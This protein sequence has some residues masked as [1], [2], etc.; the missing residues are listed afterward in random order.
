MQEPI[1]EF[2]LETPAGL[3]GFKAECENGK[4]T[5]VT[6]RNVPAF[7]ALFDAVIDV[8]E[9]GKVTVDVGWGEMLYVIA[10]VRQF[11]WLSKNRPPR[12]GVGGRLRYSNVRDA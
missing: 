3:I 10:D 9:L 5:Q 11:D 2:I 6:F 12:A 4:V 7:A 8:P 1:T